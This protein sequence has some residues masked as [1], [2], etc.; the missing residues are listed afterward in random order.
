MRTVTKEQI[1][2][3]RTAVATSILDTRSRAA[4]AFW[5]DDYA[6]KISQEYFAAMPG[7]QAKYAAITAVDPATSDVSALLAALAPLHEDMKR[8]PVG[9]AGVCLET[10]ISVPPLTCSG[11][12]EVV[13]WALEIPISAAANANPVHVCADCMRKALP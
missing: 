10:G 7:T 13:P 8:Q 12:G 1:C 3:E 5:Q 11:C 9:H 2:A 4:A 6:Y